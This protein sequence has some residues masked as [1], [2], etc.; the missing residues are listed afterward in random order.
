MLERYLAFASFDA[1]LDAS[2]CSCSFSISP[3][4]PMAFFP[5]C[6]TTIIVDQT[7]NAHLLNKIVVNDCYF[8]VPENHTGPDAIGL[9]TQVISGNL[10]TSVCDNTFT[11]FAYP[12]LSTTAGRLK[13]EIV[14]NEAQGDRGPIASF[15]LGFSSFQGHLSALIKQNTAQSFTGISAVKDESSELELRAEHNCFIAVNQPGTFALYGSGA[16]ASIDAGGGSLRSRGKNN[17]VGYA[18][19]IYAENSTISA[20]RNWWGPGTVCTTSNDCASTQECRDGFCVGPDTVIIIGSGSVDV[21]EPLSQPAQC[22]GRSWEQLLEIP[23]VSMDV[24][25]DEAQ[26]EESLRNSLVNKLY[27]LVGS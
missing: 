8:F 27:S 20:Q 21:S 22:C 23:S 6:I 24:K 7:N 13:E 9:H 15:Y 1:Q 10:E 18:T 4:Q 5:E 16:N 12:F 3:Q 14:C 19:D 11:R 17:F 25:P 2:V 26:E